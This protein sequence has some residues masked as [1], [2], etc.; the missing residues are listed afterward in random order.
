MLGNF[1]V[2]STELS[3][4]GLVASLSFHL[5]CLNAHFSFMTLLSSISFLIHFFILIIRDLSLWTAC[6]VSTWKWEPFLSSHL[7]KQRGIFHSPP[8]RSQRSLSYILWVCLLPDLCRTEVTAGTGEFGERNSACLLRHFCPYPHLPVCREATSSF[9]LDVEWA[10]FLVWTVNS[11]QRT[12]LGLYTQVRNIINLFLE[13]TVFICSSITPSFTLQLV[14][15]S[16]DKGQR[17]SEP[18]TWDSTFGCHSGYTL[19]SFED[20]ITKHKTLSAS[21]RSVN[22]AGLYGASV[23]VQSHRIELSV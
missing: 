2:V 20:L 19:L 17:I 12:S 8:W 21:L 7:S 3:P 14:M 13:A 23:V 6:M 11:I 18:G 1:S 22:F 10:T 5:S 16:G 4:R 9:L 15:D